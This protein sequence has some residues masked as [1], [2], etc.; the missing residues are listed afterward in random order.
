MCMRCMYTW[1]MHTAYIIKLL[2][3]ILLYFCL[4]F[5]SVKVHGWQDKTLSAFAELKWALNS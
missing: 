3:I 4:F 2:L 5:L 1:T